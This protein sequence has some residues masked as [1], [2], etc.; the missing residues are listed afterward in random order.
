MTSRMGIRGQFLLLLMASLIGVTSSTAFLAA[1]SQRDQL[2]QE[3]EHR[4][5]APWCCAPGRACA[6]N[7][8]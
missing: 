4:C 8:S 2:L 6:G 1:Q 3:R 7:G 5:A